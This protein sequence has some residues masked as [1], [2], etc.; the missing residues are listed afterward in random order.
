MWGDSTAQCTTA[1]PSYRIMSLKST[2]VYYKYLDRSYIW[3]TNTGK[4]DPMSFRKLRKEAGK[5]DPMVK[6]NSPLKSSSQKNLTFEPTSAPSFSMNESL[7]SEWH[8]GFTALW[9]QSEG[10]RCAWQQIHLKWT[11][12][13]WMVSWRQS[14]MIE[15]WTCRSKKHKRHC[16]GTEGK[17]SMN[18]LKC[19]WT[20]ECKGRVQSPHVIPSPECSNRHFKSS[21][22]AI[23]KVLVDHYS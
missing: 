4:C 5:I 8:S 21:E 17:T 6:T 7:N 19:A 23:I 20:A 11:G 10:R 2:W 14:T 12:T 13:D 18:R 16:W 9:S 3:Q 1:S 15:I 22:T